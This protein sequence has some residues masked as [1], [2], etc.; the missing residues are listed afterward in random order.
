[1][2]FVAEPES[3]SLCIYS[4]EADAI[5]ACEGIDVENGEYLFWNDRGEPLEA[6]ITTP[7]KRALF[8]VTSGIYQLAPA[9][10]QQH[11]P[12][13]E[14]LGEFNYFEGDAP[15]DCEAGVRNYLVSSTRG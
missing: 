6:H 11:A 10:S 2:I 9:Q 7:K 13:L 3:L 5:A 4:N 14:A 8:T 12:L 1:M 15:F